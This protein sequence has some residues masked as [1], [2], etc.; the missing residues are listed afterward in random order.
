MFLQLLELDDQKAT[1]ITQALLN[2]LHHFDFTDDYIRDHVVAFVS[3]GASVMT[4][5]KSGVAAQLT[6]L[7]PKL[8]TWHCLNHR[9]E[10]AVGDAADEAQGVSHFR[11]FMYRLYT[12]YS[13][14]P[15]T[16]K[17]LQSAARELD[18]QVKKSGVF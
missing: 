6:D 7:F 12:L 8:V 5:R 16:Q 4:G 2:C 11:S 10:L 18:I 1:T 17:H 9:L 15:K 13:C 14:S 3:D